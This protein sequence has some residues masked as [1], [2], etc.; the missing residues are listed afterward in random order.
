MSANVGESKEQS[1]SKRKEFAERFR[2]EKN[3]KKNKRRKILMGSKE[4][5]RELEN[6]GDSS[7]KIRS[8][9]PANQRPEKDLK[10]R[11]V[12][13]ERKSKETKV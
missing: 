2:E 7:V 13:E 4:E 5:I 1:P 9:K 6:S 10:R 11:E 3:L 8:K 12:K